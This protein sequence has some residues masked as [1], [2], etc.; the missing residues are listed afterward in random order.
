MLLLFS[1]IHADLEQADALEAMS[2]D[3]DVVIAAG[4]IA[5]VHRGLLET[6]D[7]LKAIDKPTVLVPGNNE[8]FEDLRLACRFWSTA[9]VLHGNGCEIDGRQYFGVGGGI[10]VTP[11]GDWSFD[12]SEEQAADLLRDMPIGAVLVSHSPPKGY[13]DQSSAGRSLGSSAVLHAMNQ[14]KSPLVVC[15]HIHGSGGQT[16]QC[17]DTTV[18]NAGPNGMVFDFEKANA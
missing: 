4:D 2:R 1:D 10:P 7:V 5:N 12:Y 18:I 8:T 6:I 14:K 16:A 15:G 13:C 3:V 11:F 9:I 17:G